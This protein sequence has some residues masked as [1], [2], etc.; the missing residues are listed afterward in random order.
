[1]SRKSLEDLLVEGK[2][3][4][5]EFLDNLGTG[6]LYPS[7]AE[8]AAAP[9]LDVWW[10]GLSRSGLGSHVCGRVTGH[11][12]VPDGKCTTSAPQYADMRR[13]WMMT[14]NTLYRLGDHM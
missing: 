10:L 11:A 12:R 1:M 2:L 8:L 7:D 13:G 5:F 3:Q 4:D 9:T 14:R 6:G